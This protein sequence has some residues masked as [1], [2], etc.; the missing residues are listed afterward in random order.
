MHNNAILAHWD[1]KQFLFLPVNVLIMRLLVGHRRFYNLDWTEM[2]ISGAKR[3][4][5]GGIRI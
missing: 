4:R 1:T 2:N 3:M 5:V